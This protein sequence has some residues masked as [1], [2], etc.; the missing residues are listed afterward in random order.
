MKRCEASA[1]KPL[2]EYVGAIVIIDPCVK[3]LKDPLK[4]AT[5][6]TSY[7]EARGG[8]MSSIRRRRDTFGGPRPIDFDNQGV[9]QQAHLQT[10]LWGVAEAIWHDDMVDCWPDEDNWQEEGS[11]EVSPMQSHW[12][13]GQGYGGEGQCS[14]FGQSS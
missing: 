9:D 6:D 14:C 11:P 2:D 12:G 1:S 8:I 4:L 7:S 5:T 13:Q 10:N 3:D